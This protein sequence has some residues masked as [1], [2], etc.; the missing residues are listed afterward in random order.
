V[1]WGEEN[2]AVLGSRAGFFVVA[3]C[4]DDWRRSQS[5]WRLRWGRLHASVPRGPRCWAS[6]R[7]EPGAGARLGGGTRE[8]TGAR[9]SSSRL[10][11]ARTRARPSVGGSAARAEQAE[12]GL[13]RATNEAGQRGSAREIG[14]VGHEWEGDGWAAGVAGWAVQ[15]KEEGGCWDVFSFLFLFLF[16]ISI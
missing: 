15:R 12:P 13:S 8:G 3:E 16:S 14:K 1:G 10:G 6:A 11:A 7:D 2:G 5:P 9:E 4:S